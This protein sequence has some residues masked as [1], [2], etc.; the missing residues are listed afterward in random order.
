MTNHDKRALR[1]TALAVATCLLTAPAAHAMREPD[2]PAAQAA[3]LKRD[4]APCMTKL[5]GPFSEN[6]CVCRKTGDK[7]PVMDKSGR[8]TSPCGNDALFCAAFRAPWAE[9]LARQGVWIANIFSRDLWLWPQFSN[10]HD[11][12]RGYILEKYF[13]DTNPTNKLAQLRASIIAMRE[14]MDKHPRQP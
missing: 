12:V 8:I 5:K 7:R 14:T 4:W 10:H 3:A 11:L 13:V 1:L 2:L 6:F 9:G